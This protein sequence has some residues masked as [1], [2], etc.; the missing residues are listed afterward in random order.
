MISFYDISP[1]VQSRKTI[2]HIMNSSTLTRA[3]N[4]FES[5]V[6]TFQARKSWPKGI[7]TRGDMINNILSA[8]WGIILV[9]W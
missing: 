7:L 2:F 3:V 6:L 4:F 8:F 9:A 5:T 1:E